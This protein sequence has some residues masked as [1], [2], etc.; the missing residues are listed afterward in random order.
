[1][2]SPLNDGPDAV[3]LGDTLADDGIQTPGYE[4]GNYADFVAPYTGDL[5]ASERCILRK[6]VGDGPCLQMAK[7]DIAAEL[8][9]TVEVVTRKLLHSLAKVKLRKE[10][11]ARAA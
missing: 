2:S 9:L 6:W 1:M 4:S 3:T 7:E 5:N 11:P 10:S 8:G